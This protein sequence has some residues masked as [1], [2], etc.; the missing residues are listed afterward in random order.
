MNDIRTV[1]FREKDGWHKRDG[2]TQTAIFAHGLEMGAWSQEGALRER[3][4]DIVRELSLEKDQ[5][6][7]I[8]HSQ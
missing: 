5:V 2:R 8:G 1:Y 6:R 7:K 3:G 4:R